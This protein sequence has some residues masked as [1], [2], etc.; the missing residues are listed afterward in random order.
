DKSERPTLP[1][2]RRSLDTEE[3][4]R[5][6]AATDKKFRSLVAVGLFGG[7][8]ISEALG[9][10]WE[11]V[12]FER[13]VIRVRRQIARDGSRARIELKTQRSRRDVV[14]VPELGH[15]LKEHRMATKHK[16]PTE[17][18]FAMP[19]RRARCQHSTA[20]VIQRAAKKARLEGVT[21][22]TLRHAFASMLI[23]G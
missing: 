9:L 18:V 14:L 12:D 17:L 22:H 15:M 19:D 6:L 16:A 8:R 5:L 20:A 3:T 7:L 1:G 10:T 2:E 11:D 23:T 13:G 21:Y 4:K